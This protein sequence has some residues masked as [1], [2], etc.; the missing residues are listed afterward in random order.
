DRLHTRGR[1]R[2]TLYTNIFRSLPQ[3]REGFFILTLLPEN[4]V[5]NQ[6]TKQKEQNMKV[7][8]VGATGLV[9]TKM[10]QVLAERNFPVTELL[11]V[12]SER[13]IG[14]EVTF[15]NKNYKVVGYA[16]AIA[17]KP[18]LALFSAGGSVS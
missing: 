5:F 18:A 16:D 15:K 12:A 7:A 2:T 10:L 1:L 8:V 17:M 6:K 3:K 14:K 11:P 4:G 13:S 9:G